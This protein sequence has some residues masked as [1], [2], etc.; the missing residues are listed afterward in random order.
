MSVS[1]KLT[2]DIEVVVV[3]HNCTDFTFEEVNQI[4]DPRVKV[5]DFKTKESGKGI[6][7]N[8]GLE[9]ANG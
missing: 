5:Y 7:L 8:F 4:A 3:C 2:K 6:A 1:I 9:Q